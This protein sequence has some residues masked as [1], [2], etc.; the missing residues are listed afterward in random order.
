MN[1]EY[2]IMIGAAVIMLSFIIYYENLISKTKTVET[3]IN[4]NYYELENAPTTFVTIG[5]LGTC[6]G[7]FL[8]LLNFNTD[9][10]HIKESVK[11]LLSGLRFAFLVTIVGLILSLIYKQRINYILNLYGDIQPPESPEFAE[12]KKLIYC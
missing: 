5:L 12:M 4:L 8:G 1:Y 6:A 11:E 7:I 2:L 9:S 3:R 10:G